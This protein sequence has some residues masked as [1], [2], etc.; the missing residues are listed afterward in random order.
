MLSI[1]LRLCNNLDKFNTWE[2]SESSCKL[3]INKS[4]YRQ[5]YKY[6]Y[7]QEYKYVYRQEYKYVYRQE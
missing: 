3:S 4:G 6:I 1:I 5:E 2:L 7:R